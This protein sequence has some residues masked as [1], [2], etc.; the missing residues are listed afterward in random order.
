MKSV[1]LYPLICLLLPFSAL[2]RKTSY[3]QQLV[4]LADGREQELWIS[5]DEASDL[6]HYKMTPEGPTSIYKAADVQ[7]FLYSG[8][9]Y[10]SLLLRDG[11]F[12][13]FKVHHEGGEFAVLEK[14]PNYKALRILVEESGGRLSICQNRRSN[15]FYLCYTDN[16]PTQVSSRLVFP[17]ST[18]P[19]RKREFE[20][21]KLVYLAIE[22]KLAL[23]YMETNERFTLWDDILSQRPGKQQAGKM[24]ENFIDDP[25]KRTAIQ[26]K[27][28]QDK[29]DLRDPRHLILALEAVYQ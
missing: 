9:Q 11:Y 25:Q 7:S 28:Q 6:L 22:G 17:A 21:R 1:I 20:V 12:T 29:L 24:L 10:Y 19:T 4:L 8:Q 16:N 26:K 14:T 23:F 13:F 5:M 3:E 2:A 27:I 15:E 18:M